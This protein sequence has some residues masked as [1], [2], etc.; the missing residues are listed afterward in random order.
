MAVQSTVWKFF[1]KVDG[2]TKCL[3]CSWFEKSDGK[4]ATGN[5]WRH[6]ESAHS[7]VQNVLNT[8]L[9][10]RPG[11]ASPI[12]G[13]FKAQSN[14][15]MKLSCVLLVAVDL[16]PFSIFEGEGSSSFPRLF[17]SPPLSLG[18]RTYSE[19]IK[20]WDVPCAKTV[21]L[22]LSQTFAFVQKSTFLPL[23][24]FPSAQ[25]LNSIPRS[26]ENVRRCDC[27]EWDG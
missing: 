6:L 2:T 16:R 17:L 20:N 7:L 18:F 15:H 24:S 21:T 27:L 13:F 19:G 25:S 3:H 26:H 10:P 23:L 22:W 11:P 8:T 9:A 5:L 12:L 14:A 4:G 1:D